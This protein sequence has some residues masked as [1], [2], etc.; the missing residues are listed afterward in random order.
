MANKLTHEHKIELAAVALLVLWV[1][2]WGISLSM[3]VEIPQ[4]LNVVMPMASA[5]L[6][7]FQ[8]PIGDGKKK[9]AK[10]S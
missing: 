4:A 10:E 5:A 8:L 7:G 2:A 3:G 9:G 6:L 1:A